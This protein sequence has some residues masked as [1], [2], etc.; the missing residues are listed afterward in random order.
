M[1][2]YKLYL[3]INVESMVVNELLVPMLMPPPLFPATLSA[4]NL[5]SWLHYTRLMKRYYIEK[6]NSL[7]TKDLR[8]MSIL[9]SRAAI[10]PP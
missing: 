9:L 10:A 2:T 6:Q 7:D 1:S 3:R 5:V 8:I 4:N